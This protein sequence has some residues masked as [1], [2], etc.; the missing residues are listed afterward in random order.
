MHKLNIPKRMER[1]AFRIQLLWTLSLGQWVCRPQDFPRQNTTPVEGFDFESG[2]FAHLTLAGLHFGLGD[3]LDMAW[4]TSEK[5][6]GTH[7][8]IIIRMLLHVSKDKR[9]KNVF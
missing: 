8:Q 4:S 5:S 6:P 3:T 9:M 2:V 1:N 7:A